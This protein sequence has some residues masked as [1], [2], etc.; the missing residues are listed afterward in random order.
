MSTAQGVISLIEDREND[1]SQEIFVSPISRYAIV[2][3]KILLDI[4]SK[5]S[6]LRY[7]VDLTR[8]IFYAGQ[9]EYAQTVLQSPWFNLLLITA[10]FAVFLALGTFLFVRGERNR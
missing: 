1:F 8:G 2:F 9:P 6:P 4:L 5:I 10:L 3:D 7:A